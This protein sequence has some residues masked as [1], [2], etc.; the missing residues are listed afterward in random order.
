[1]T[2]ETITKEKDID[3]TETKEILNKWNY[4]QSLSNKLLF[5]YIVFCLIALLVGG[6]HLILDHN[7]DIKTKV[8]QITFI[9]NSGIVG[10]TSILGTLISFKSLLS[11]PKLDT[12][13][14][15]IKNEKRFD[16]NR[17]AEDWCCENL[18]ELKNHEKNRKQLYFMK[19]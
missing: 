5:I 13:D 17:Y 10:S 16:I 12:I 14:E 7:S 18:E 1:M 8:L 15:L 19:N 3:I 4:F 9:S 2:E 11:V 6:L